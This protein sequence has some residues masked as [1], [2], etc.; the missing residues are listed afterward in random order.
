MAHVPYSSD[1][2]HA[3]VPQRSYTRISEGSTISMRG[4]PPLEKIVQTIVPLSVV[5][6]T[7]VTITSCGGP[8][9]RFPRR[10]RGTV[11]IAART[12]ST[13]NVANESTNA[14]NGET[15]APVGKS[16]YTWKAADRNITAS[17]T[18]G[19]CAIAPTGAPVKTGAIAPTGA[20]VKKYTGALV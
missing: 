2:M 11:D 3:P 6:R 18:T 20:P 10:L 7:A 5:S 4:C 13:T 1:P 9:R 19:I 12:S 8:R 17:P 15:G 16:S 14:V